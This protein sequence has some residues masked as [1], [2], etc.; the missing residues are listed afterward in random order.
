MYTIDLACAER[1][2]GWPGWGRDLVIGTSIGEKLP[3]SASINIIVTLLHLVFEKNFFH[4]KKFFFITE[5]YTYL[6]IA[7]V[8]PSAKA[9]ISCY[10]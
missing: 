2:R 5:I 8:P 3:F 4:E 1:G 6:P 10:N 9:P 7:A